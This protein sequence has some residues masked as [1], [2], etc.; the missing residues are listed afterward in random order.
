MFVINTYLVVSGVWTTLML[1]NTLISLA[2]LTGAALTASVE[3]DGNPS[4]LELEQF[5]SNQKLRLLD[6]SHFTSMLKTGSP[7]FLSE[8]S[9]HFPHIHRKIVS[10]ED[11]RAFGQALPRND[12]FYLGIALLHMDF[13]TSDAELMSYV[14]AIAGID[15]GPLRLFLEFPVITGQTGVHAR[16]KGLFEILELD[17]A[18]K[19]R[20][21]AVNDVKHGNANDIYEIDRDV[22]FHVFSYFAADFEA[23]SCLAGYI[24]NRPEL[25]DAWAQVARSFPTAKNSRLYAVDLVFN[26]T[27]FFLHANVLNDVRKFLLAN[28]IRHFWSFQPTQLTENIARELRQFINNLVAAQRPMSV[29]EEDILLASLNLY[30]LKEDAEMVQLLT[31]YF[32]QHPKR[33]YGAANYQLPYDS[34]VWMGPLGV[35]YV[36]HFTNANDESIGQLAHRA[37]ILHRAILSKDFAFL[38]EIIMGGEELM[39]EATASGAIPAIYADETQFLLQLLDW[40]AT[41]KPSATA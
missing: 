10:V 28:F 5:P 15:E 7:G 33:M 16:N 6:I 25:A 32:I 34:A 31:D 12:R 13:D 1:L 2:A 37:D 17:H 30:S 38:S 18:T 14:K 19:A 20:L 4:K 24:C 35:E 36:N 26:P 39:D 27:E 9:R 11:V 8:C 3:I 40:M 23:L 29:L 21:N 22:L 41:G